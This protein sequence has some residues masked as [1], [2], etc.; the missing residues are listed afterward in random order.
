LRL[1]PEDAQAH[2]NLANVL[3]EQGRLE[4]AVSEYGEAL[5][6]NPDH[7]P[8]AHYNLAL[9]LSRQGKRQEAIN[10]VTEALRA[11]PDYPDAKRQLELLSAPAAR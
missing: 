1:K 11:R 8:E 3:M 2:N 5:R 9:A 10:H 4:D 6:L 7:N